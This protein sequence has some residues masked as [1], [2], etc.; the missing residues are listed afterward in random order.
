LRAV[1]L[2]SVV[3]PV[4]NVEPY[5]RACL[6]SIAR[7]THG[8][9][10][11]IVVDD[12][13]TDG[14]AAIARA[15][16]ERDSR[17]RVLSQPN[18]GL[19]NARNN[20][21]AEARGELLAFVDSD[22]ELPANA[23]EL[24]LG[25]L[26]RSGSDF[27]T[28]N[29]HR[30]DESGATS[31]AAFL[32][33][34]FADSRLRT[35]VTRFRPL[36][37]DRIAPNKLWRRSFWEAQAFRF[38]ERMLH[39]DIPV[40]VPAQ[41]AARSVDVVSEPVY[42]YRV[43]EGSD[44]SITQ[45]RAELRALRDRLRAIEMVLGWFGSHRMRRARRWYE[46]SIVAHDLRYYLN[47]LDVASD[48]YRGFFLE[49]V[50][51]LL[52]GA[53]ARGLF[54]GLLAIDR[55]KWWLVRRRLLDELLEVLRFE[56]KQ[57]RDT[58]PLRSRGRWYGDYPFRGD[59]RLRVPRSVYRLDRELS[60]D[61]RLDGARFD[62][63]ELRLEGY[64][65]VRGLGAPAPDSQRVAIG[66]VRPG[67]LRALRQRLAPAR[68]SVTE[69]E[70]RDATAAVRDSWYSADWSGFTGSLDLTSVRGEGR[71][72]LHVTVRSHGV[73]RRRAR[74]ATDGVRALRAASQVLS[75]GRLAS[76]APGP[77]GQVSVRVDSRW[78]LIAD[79]PVAEGV[80]ELRGRAAGDGVLELVG[81]GGSGRLEYAFSR[82]GDSFRVRIPLAELGDGIDWELGL[83]GGRVA[84]QEE[85]PEA[86][87]EG[88]LLR[89]TRAGG[90]SLSRG[91]AALVIEEARWHDGSL[92]LSGSATA[93]AAELVAVGRDTL[94]RHPFP[95]T[96][97]RGRFEATLPAG[98]LPLRHDDWDLRAGEKELPLLVSRLL[99]GRARTTYGSRRYELGADADGRALL[100]AGPDLAEDE[101]GAFHQR[102]LRETSYAAKRAEP[103]VESVVYASFGGRTCADSPRAIHAELVRRGAALE[104]LW[105]VHDGMCR[106]PDTATVLR[107]GSREHHEA[108]ARARYVVTN[109]ELPQWFW[110]RDG[111]V[112]LQT[113]HGTPLLR[114]R[115]AA[116]A[117]EW[118]HT[119][120][121]SA[122]AS[123]L[124]RTALGL[125]R[126]PLETGLP[127]LD[128]LRQGAAADVRAHLGLS[129]GART[130][131]YAPTLREDVTDRRGRHRLD[132]HLD[133]ERLHGAL[134]DDTVL[135]FR[136]HPRVLGALPAAA[137]R[138]AQD[139][140]TYP[141]ATELLLAVD[142]LVTDYSSIMFDFAN[143]GRPMVFFAYDLD[144]RRDELLLDYEGTVP[145]PIART[146]DELAEAL[147]TT[148]AGGY[149]R[150]Y[151]EFAA[152]FCELDDGHAA[153]RVVE[154]VFER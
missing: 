80:L 139:V 43:R 38:P 69:V 127:R 82:A 98:A 2:V 3:V 83:R 68:M 111:Q 91:A 144:A 21:A 49:R 145:G 122:S 110:R 107:D 36:L 77:T 64:G 116:G 121:P 59:R 13:S 154:R 124:L 146:T 37:E 78:A 17:F 131:L 74:F 58:P 71:L 86:V 55:L 117:A 87:G 45:R 32:A 51:A 106:P 56:R 113:W 28:G 148:D 67:R 5:L 6:E 26:E 99:G 153:A 135:L 62:G 115:G 15:F 63:D 133:L 89:S 9:L 50:N 48:E 44:P 100:G 60:L 97:A 138:L 96:G 79:A 95:L 143:T 20:G 125:E 109:D 52:D 40:V 54:G 16:A 147:R 130:V 114:R 105:L 39:E 14:S 66:L 132:F 33:R 123:P 1:P 30:L 29:V 140:S 61:P 70:R 137:A 134:P 142:V 11:V 149:E 25:S 102:R 92:V 73:T 41:F 84:V 8:E 129:D 103:L 24:L 104:H 85:V 108:L 136:R 93:D 7:Q 22:D 35:H 150:R 19:G 90:A 47:V 151:A 18:G 4:Y 101:R 141:D 53:S 152:C 128:A 27:A 81:S 112:C 119:L 10:E 76:V 94:E 46:R 120:S 88:L 65:F 31:Q 126:E 34:T 118:S 57:L 12:G 72:D 42:L 75:D 23:Y